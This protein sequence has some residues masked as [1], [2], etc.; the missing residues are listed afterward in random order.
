MFLYL[1]SIPSSDGGE[2]FP[3]LPFF[4]FHGDEKVVAVCSNWY[5]SQRVRFCANLCKLLC[6]TG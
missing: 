4:V 3:K 1:R 6:R 5:F 2:T